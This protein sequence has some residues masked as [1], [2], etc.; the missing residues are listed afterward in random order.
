[1]PRRSHH[2]A[3]GCPSRLGSTLRFGH[4][5]EA[6]GTQ[7]GGPGQESQAKASFPL[8]DNRNASMLA[9]THFCRPGRHTHTRTAGDGPK[10][11][12]ARSIPNLQLH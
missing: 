9:H 6:V 3:A 5:A 1:M 4:G 8:K 10:A 12:L 11:L 2:R 7:V